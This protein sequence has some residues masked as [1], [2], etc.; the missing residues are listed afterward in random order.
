MLAS[1]PADSPVL[2]GSSLWAVIMIMAESFRRAM[3]PA[4]TRTCP[5]VHN[6]SRWA[7]L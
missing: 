4:L 3:R 7:P 6:P 2:P 5:S 1:D